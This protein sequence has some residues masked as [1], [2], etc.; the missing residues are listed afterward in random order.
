M[1][2]AVPKLTEDIFPLE[3]ED[4][5]SS[6]SLFMLM[7][8]RGARGSVGCLGDSA[9]AGGSAPESCG[10]PAMEADGDTGHHTGP[11]PLT[12]L[13]G[14]QATYPLPLPT[15]TPNTPVSDAII[16]VVPTVIHYLINKFWS[17]PSLA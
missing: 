16:G 15:D 11:R 17:S 1:K 10:R 14:P 6:P 12:L 4:G 13:L 3:G 2:A 5:A 9:E 7:L 8:G